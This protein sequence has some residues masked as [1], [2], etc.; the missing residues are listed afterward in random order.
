MCYGYTTKYLLMDLFTLCVNKST[1]LLFF[2]ILVSKTNQVRVP[3]WLQFI[4]NIIYFVVNNVL[5]NNLIVG[6]MKDNDIIY[7][8]QNKQNFFAQLQYKG[9]LQVNNNYNTS[10]WNRYTSA[11]P[12][13]NLSQVR[14]LIFYLSNFFIFPVS[15]FQHSLFVYVSCL[16]SN[17]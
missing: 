10:I 15:T 5:N 4:Y 14:Y 3:E 8:S 1:Q 6:K 16:L 13:V 12:I 17:K 11:L 7:I 2:Q 9:T